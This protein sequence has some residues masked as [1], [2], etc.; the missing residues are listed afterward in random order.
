M[1]ITD[2]S[3]GSIIAKGTTNHASKTYEFSHF[4]SPSEPVHSQ[5]PL[6]RE[7][8]IIASTSFTTSTSIADPSLLVYEIEI[9][10]DSDLDSVPTS[11]LEARK[12]IGNSPDTQKG[13]TLA[14][15]HAILPPL[16]RCN[17]LP[18]RCYMERMS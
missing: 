10:G 13:K 5:Q 16:E 4:M 7:G 9:Q 14:L 15:C 12:M 2:I 17:R 18:I 11:K 8:K 6:A 1:E 3:T